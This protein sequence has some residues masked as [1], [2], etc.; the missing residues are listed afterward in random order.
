MRPSR[1]AWIGCALFA[2]PLV[3]HAYAGTASRYVSD[4]YC[5]GYIFRDHGYLG[6][7]WWFYMHWGAVP[8]T[9]LLMAI[10]DPL[11]SDLTPYLTLAAI[12]A[13]VAALTWGVRR[14]SQA[15]GDRWDRLTALL[16]AEVLV[17]ATLQ[18]SPNVVQSLYL[19][20]PMFEYVLPLVALALYAGW[21]CGDRSR[22]QS[23]PRPVPMIIS[24]VA[25]FVAGSLGPTYVVLQTTVLGMGIVVNRLVN[26]GEG[27]RAFERLLIA[28]LIGSIVAMAF[29]ALAPGNAARQQAY[30]PPPGLVRLV[31][32]TFLS[33]MFVFARPLLPLLRGAIAAI[34]PHVFSFQ[35]E[36]LPKALDMAS[37]PLTILV[38][39]MV[40]GLIG[41]VRGPAK[42]G[43]H[44]SIL[45][46]AP[47]VAFILVA[48]CVA[49]SVY[50]TSA[51]PPPRAL[52]EP[53]FVLACALFCWSYAAGAGLRARDVAVRGPAAIALA[54]VL[55]VVGAVPLVAA[56]GIAR[57]GSEYRAWAARW[58]QTDAQLRAAAAQG[59]KNAQVRALDQIG[60]VPA[61]VE[62]PTNWVNNCAAR[63]Y[64]LET[65]TGAAA[66]Q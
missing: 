7:Q 24:A 4:D 54:I 62:D 45:L 11:G 52:I 28:G 37:S 29:V 14:I 18:D 30:P 43:R 2:L 6:G 16:V 22:P 66:R 38:L 55:G 50:G 20:I 56:R 47:I 26:R 65:I 3:A 44:G 32:L 27:A 15:L 8:A 60:G 64:G 49:P 35:P 19:R 12:A 17:Y 1:L 40:G 34:V 58:D 63:Y 59:V 13:W 21:L 39:V 61:I 51:P 46:G 23:S 42:A 41:I 57:Q 48:A 25:M 36:W 10:T 33:T 5:A 31:A 53:Q 9:L